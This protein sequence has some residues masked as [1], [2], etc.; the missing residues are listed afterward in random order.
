MAAAALGAPHRPVSFSVPT[1]NFGDI[2]AGYGA[3]RMG[4][5]IERLV[6]ATNDNDILRRT[7]ATGVYEVRGVVA[8][9]SPS[10]DIQV[11]SNFERY[12]FEASDRDAAWVRGRMGALA[13]SGRLRAVGTRAG[14]PARGLR[15]RQRQHGRGRRAASG[16]VKAESGYLLEPHTACGVIACEK[17]PRPRRYARS[18]ARHRAPGEVPR[19]HGGDHRRAP[20]AAASGWHP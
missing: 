14:R 10:M 20:R 19:C 11:S 7:H 17:T 15:R 2:F 18:R 3:R 13:Q 6:I 12:L 1:G 9:T 5:P 8:T 16:R 4:L